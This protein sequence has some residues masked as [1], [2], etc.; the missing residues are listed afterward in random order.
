MSVIIE[1]TMAATKVFGNSTL[2]SGFSSYAA[3][4]SC[5]VCSTDSFSTLGLVSSISTC[6]L[7]GWI[8]ST[9]TGCS[10]STS[11]S[12]PVSSSIVTGL[13]LMKDF[14]YVPLPCHELYGM[15]EKVSL[16]SSSFSILH[17]SVPWLYFNVPGG[18]TSPTSTT[19]SS[20]NW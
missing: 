8:S 15:K 4:G 7:T 16:Q 10:C 11:S 5:Y 3:T 13:S 14:D 6:G 20:P 9:T 1:I 17:P 2:H 12:S 19:R 18:T